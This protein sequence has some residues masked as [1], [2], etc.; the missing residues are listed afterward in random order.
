MQNDI[1]DKTA[2]R[3]DETVD[4]YIKRICSFKEALNLSWQKIA[5]IVE[6]QT[7]FKRCEKYY[8]S[9]YNNFVT[10][11]YV[12]IIP[13][14]RETAYL[15]RVTTKA[16]SIYDDSEE[17]DE[18]ENILF[19]IKKERYK[20]NETRA[21]INADARRISRE[22]TLK[23]I[24]HDFASQMS[25]KKMLDPVAVHKVINDE[26]AGILLISDWHYGIECFNYW[27]KFNPQIA[28]QRVSELLNKVIRYGQENN[29]DKL[30][31]LNLGDM[32]C[33]RI[34]LALRLQSRIDVITQI[35]E[36]SEILAEFLNSLAKYFNVEYF[37]CFDNHSR[38]EPNKQDALQLETL[39]RL[40]PWY[41]L[42]RLKGSV[43]IHQN[44][45]DEDIITF[46]CLNYRVGAVHGDKD[47]PVTIVQNLT[48]MNREPYDLICSAHLHHHSE[49]ERNQTEIICNGSLMGTDEYAK[50]LR[51]TGK[52]SQT[53]IISGK[54]SVRE[55]VYKID[56]N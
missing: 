12:Q 19:D 28:R 33:G 14:E 36:V 25:D 17:S 10:S 41:L 21:Q 40:I 24:A 2:I 26:K 56:L 47:K 51:L 15:D 39:T 8:R 50:E 45:F 6:E 7:G 18:L 32:I 22:E 44:R 23:E 37:Q 16:E 38:I 31:V 52:P 34:H 46:N 11:G 53:L 5:D 29:I 42:E 55:I 49:D 27:N 54:N 3:S 9:K 20:L 48:L 43:L 30:Y 4:S 13:Q 1:Y 35:M